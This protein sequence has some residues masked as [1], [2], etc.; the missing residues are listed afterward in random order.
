[1]GA[2]ATVGRER[3]R[4]EK[5]EENLWMMVRTWTDW[6]HIRESLGTSGLEKG[7]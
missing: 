4:K 5:H 2:P 3:E 6:N 7:V 1:V